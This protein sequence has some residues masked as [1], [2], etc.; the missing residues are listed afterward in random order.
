MKIN[1]KTCQSKYNKSIGFIEKLFSSK[2]KYKNTWDVKKA[3]GDIIKIK[4]K[5]FL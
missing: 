2:S 5:I 4:T 1:S 3:K